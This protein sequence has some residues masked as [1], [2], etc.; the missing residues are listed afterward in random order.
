MA[1]CPRCAQHLIDGVVC[2]SCGI[3]D[4]DDSDDY[5]YG[6]HHDIGDEIPSQ[7]TERCPLCRYTMEC[8]ICC[9][10]CGEINCDCPIIVY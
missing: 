5:V 3:V 1:K 4:W 8:C 7:E 10:K 9:Y 6:F 2:D